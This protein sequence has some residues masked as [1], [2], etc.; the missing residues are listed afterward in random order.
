MTIPHA[1]CG[2]IGPHCKQVTDAVRF[3]FAL[4]TVQLDLIVFRSLSQGPVRDWRSPGSIGLA[5][6]EG[7]LCWLLPGACDAWSKRERTLTT[8]ARQTSKSF[9][10]ASVN[11]LVHDHP[12]GYPSPLHPRLNRLDIL[13]VV[14]LVQYVSSRGFLKRNNHLSSLPAC[15]SRRGSSRTRLNTTDVS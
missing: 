1:L 7:E 14:V 2:T 11:L 12:S 3:L 8:R 9:R 15:S 13:V 4:R 10:P 6:I 5:R